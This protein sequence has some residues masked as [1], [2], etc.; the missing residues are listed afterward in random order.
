MDEELGR[1]PDYLAGEIHALR[2]LLS[3]LLSQMPEAAVYLAR[4]LCRNTIAG[5]DHL[6]R[7]TQTDGARDFAAGVWAVMA[8]VRDNAGVWMAKRAEGSQLATIQ[9]APIADMALRAIRD[10]FSD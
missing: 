10:P 6:V 2:S 4:N 9:P 8:P 1:T 7:E 3:Q 5:A